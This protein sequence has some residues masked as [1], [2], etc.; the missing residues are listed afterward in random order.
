MVPPAHVNR[1][2][3]HTPGQFARSSRE[4]HDITGYGI[5]EF[6]VSGY[7]NGQIASD[8]TGNEWSAGLGTL[9]SF[10]EST[11]AFTQYAL[12]H[13][14]DEAYGIALSPDRAAMW[15][16]VPNQNKREIGCMKLSNGSVKT[17][18]TPTKVPDAEFIAAGP[19][20]AMWFNEGLKSRV[21]RID[22]STFTV[23][24]FAIPGG[25]SYVGAITL[26]SDGALW[27]IEQSPNAIARIT[28]GGQVSSYSINGNIPT[29]LTTGPDGAIWF[30]GESD[31][32]NSFVGRIDLLTHGR[33]LY[34]YGVGNS[35]N[36]GIV[37][38]DSDLWMTRQGGGTS[39]E[40]RIDRFDT[41]THLIH[42]RRIP[43]GYV[44]QEGIALGADHQLWFTDW[45]SSNSKSAIG[46]LCPGQSSDEC[47]VS[48]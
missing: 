8:G 33:K 39:D 40:F 10:N 5:A 41:T 44:L 46:K 48:Q 4:T 34:K 9:V 1:A 47:A 36:W 23:T 20:N 25:V 31:H 30:T 37:T 43:Q 17:F 32:G 15:F 38:R 26:G 2:D 35:E 18:T 29:A 13:S 16:A 27:F 12:D 11:H 6:P 45:N 28:T 19:D 21:G 14:G 22:L 42:S 24:E 3:R 7:L